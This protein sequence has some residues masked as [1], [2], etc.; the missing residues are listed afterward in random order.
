MTVILY[1]EGGGDHNKA[2]DSRCR[3]GFRKFIEKSGLTGRMP[4]I[5]ACGGRHNA[6]ES[7]RTALRRREADRICLLLVDSEGPVQV[8]NPWDHV[9]RRVGDEWQ[10]PEAAG[11]DQ[12]HLMVQAMEA[13][14]YAD[15]DRVASF[16]GPGFQRT[17][18]TGRA[19]IESIPKA[20]LIAGL[21]RAT[22]GCEKKGP[23]SKGDHSFALLGGISPQRVRASSP[24]SARFLDVLNRFLT[25]P[26]QEPR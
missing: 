17:A 21:K 16:Y 22:A 19:D 3:E 11:N 9:S 2:L 1:V 18:L 24:W 7:F 26:V 4:R 10:R 5:V 13:W 25:P 15:L 23:Y 14:F 12:L 20:E 8:Q 6:F